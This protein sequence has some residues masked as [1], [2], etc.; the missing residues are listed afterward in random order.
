MYQLFCDSNSEIPYWFA[1]ENG[2]AVVRM[3]YVICDEEYYYDLGEHTDFV[4][5]YNKERA[6]NMPTT[7]ALNA[8]N[9]LEI[10]EPTLAAGTDILMISFSSALSG[11]H[12]M[13]EQARQ[14]L[15]E[16]YPERTFNVVNTL[17]I[18]MGAGLIVY[19]ATQM[20]KAGATQ[21][22]IISWVEEN[23]MKVNHWFSVDDLHHLKRGG[24]LSGAAAFVGSVLELKPILTVNSEGKL[25]VVGKAKGRKRALKTMLEKMEQNIVDPENQLI[26]VLHADAP[27][28]AKFLEESIRSTYNPKE[29]WVNYVGPVIGTHCGPGTVALLFMGKDRVE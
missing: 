22:E 21:Q 23:R 26:V 29:L 15:L 18:S 4:D 17:S 24:R 28:D 6:G 7:A 5:F 25:I 10:Y 8:Q 1:K 2:L 13:L 14:E 12:A 3:P 9:Y 16:K 27:E 11:T 19:Y 20:W